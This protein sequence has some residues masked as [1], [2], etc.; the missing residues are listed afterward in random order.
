MWQQT[1]E[2]RLLEWTQLRQQCSTGDLETTLHTI[3]NWWWR[4]PMINYHLHWDDVGKWPDPWQLLADNHWCGLA[5][6]LGILYTIEIIN[7]SDVTDCGVL[8]CSNGD[9]LVQINREKYILN[10]SPRQ[11]VNNLPPENIITRC[12]DSKELQNKLG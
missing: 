1:F 6:A 7:R 3:N 8:Q 10:W 4:A 12:I 9:N 2:E 11:I 5:R